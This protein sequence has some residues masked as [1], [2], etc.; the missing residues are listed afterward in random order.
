VEELSG[1]APV[2]WL[3]QVILLP[4]LFFMNVH[5]DLLTKLIQK[6]KDLHYALKVYTNPESRR[7][8]RLF[9][10]HLDAVKIYKEHP[11]IVLLDCT[12][13]TN[14]LCMPLLNICTVT[15]NK[16]TIQIALYFLSGEK[17]ASYAWPMQAF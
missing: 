17:E 15:G 1:K 4:F 8:E 6:L 2:E 11:N 14:R 10:A 7:L 12:Y 13:K 16:K 5:E 9:F 3:L